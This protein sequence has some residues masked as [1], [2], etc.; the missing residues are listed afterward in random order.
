MV[1]LCSNCRLSTTLT[2]PFIPLNH[3][4][5]DDFPTQFFRYPDRFFCFS[6]L[7]SLSIFSFSESRIFTN[8]TDFAD[9]VGFRKFNLIYEYLSYF[10]AKM[11]AIAIT[12]VVKLIIFHISRSAKTL[13]IG[14]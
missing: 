12:M 14:L 1:N 13:I 8:Y 9:Y 7:Y 6:L 2:P 5:T 4:L 3:L 10:N 11:D